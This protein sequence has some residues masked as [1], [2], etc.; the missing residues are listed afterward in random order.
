MENAEAL[1]TMLT[2]AKIPAYR[3]EFSNIVYF[4]KPRNQ[5]FVNKWQLAC[6]EGYAHVVLMPHVS[7]E[8][9]KLF[10]DELIQSRTVGVKENIADLK[11]K[12]F[13]ASGGK[14]FK[15]QDADNSLFD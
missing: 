1:K 4:Q 7:V 11:Y 15:I 6:G 3:N 5:D 10:V 13:A 9:M 2:K 12:K 14:T 8:K